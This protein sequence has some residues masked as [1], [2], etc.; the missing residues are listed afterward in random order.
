[1]T[2]LGDASRLVPG[3]QLVGSATTSFARVHSDTRTIAP[4]DLFVALRG[5]RFDAHAF[6]G[7]AKAKGAVAAL[8]E[9]GLDD[10][11]LPGLLVADSRR[12][13][14]DFAA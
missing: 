14:G 8:A 4:G 1:M 6:L 12:A 3:A 13:L 11:A 10:A 7:D 2:T 9:R 5:E